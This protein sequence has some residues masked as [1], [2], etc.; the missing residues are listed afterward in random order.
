MPALRPARPEDAPAVT[1]LVR[2]AYARWV[3]LLGREPAPMTAD[4]PGLIAAGAVSLLEDSG[5]LLGVLVLITEPDALMVENVAVAPAAQRRGLGAMLLD[6][7]DRVARAAGRDRMRLYT[8]AAMGANIA[9]YARRGF[10]ETRRVTEHGL[11]RV[12]M[13]RRLD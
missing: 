2:A 3:P 13:E 10:V 12:Y 7:A 9:Y 11:H 4:Y 1:A 6:E 5:V 8:N